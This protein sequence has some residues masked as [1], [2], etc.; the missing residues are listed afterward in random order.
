MT[1]QQLEIRSFLETVHGLQ[2]ERVA[3]INYLGKKKRRYDPKGR[4]FWVR[5]SDWKKAYVTFKPPPEVQAQWEAAQQGQVAQ[6]VVQARQAQLPAGGQ[7][8]PQ[9]PPQQPQQQPPEQPPQ[10]PQS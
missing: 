7:Q 1:T 5:L 10:L 2:V 3:T 8:A 9:Q 4:S 6:A